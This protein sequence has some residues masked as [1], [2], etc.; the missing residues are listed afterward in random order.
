MGEAAIRVEDL[1]KIYRPDR[2]ELSVRAVDGLTFEVARGESVAITG[3]SGCGKSTLL[4][5]LGC[6][7]RP[8]GGLYALA[9][10]DVS[11]LSDDALA[12]L[13]NRHIG[14][15]FQIF[16]LLPRQD[17]LENVALPLLYSGVSRTR[18]RALQ[19]L[20]RVGLADR[21]HHLPSE[22]SGGQRQRVAIARAVVTRP[23]VLLC[24]EPTGALDSHT[25]EEVLDL[26]GDLNA[27]GTTVVVVTHDAHVA[28]RQGR[29]L[30]M[31][32]GRIEGD[33]RRAT[34]AGGARVAAGDSRGGA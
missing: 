27:E 25:G 17:A 21:A 11:R 26:L 12:R 29:I 2:P 1:V 9:G 31:R 30:R 10:E 23:A 18:E 15:V 28:E 20:E 5:V 4:H 34:A 33:E 14:F 3:P 32:D 7:D 6:L 16:N 22:L 8:T 13:R 19:A 24:D